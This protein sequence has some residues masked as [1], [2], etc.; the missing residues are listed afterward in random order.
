M[1]HFRPLFKEAEQ[2]NKSVVFSMD[3]EGKMMGKV[4]FLIP[5]RK[6]LQ[7]YIGVNYNL[8]ISTDKDLK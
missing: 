8:F 2:V 7:L 4:A 3:A 1:L 6:S 5:Q